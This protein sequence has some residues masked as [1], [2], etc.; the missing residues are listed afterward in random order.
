MNEKIHNNENITKEEM[1]KIEK[2]VNH[3]GKFGNV[4]I[5]VNNG[6]IDLISSKRIRIRNRYHQ[7]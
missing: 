3:V 4:D 1:E 7:G 6:Q 2:A 5:I